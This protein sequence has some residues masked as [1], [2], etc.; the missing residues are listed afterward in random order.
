[1]AD[2][3]SPDELTQSRPAFPSLGELTQPPL[4]ALV[5]YAARCARR[6][7]PLFTLPDDHP[8]KQKHSEAVER[9]VRTAEEVARGTL[10]IDDPRVCVPVAARAL[11]ATSG[12]SGASGAAWASTD[13]ARAAMATTRAARGEQGSGDFFPLSDEPVAW[14]EG[15]RAGDAWVAYFAWSAAAAPWAYA[16]NAR[17]AVARSDFAKLRGLGLGRFP[18]LGAPIDPSENGPLGPLW[19]EAQRGADAN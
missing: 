9:A 17:G 10:V 19:P 5:A 1:M 18:E 2:V 3:P 16:A 6:V 8:D 11:D 13:A 12:V 4:R 14:P 7:Q 15:T